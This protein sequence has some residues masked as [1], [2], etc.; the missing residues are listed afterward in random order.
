V[1]IDPP[2]RRNGKCIVCGGPR[3]P[4]RSRTYGG[5]VAELDPFCCTEHCKIWHGVVHPVGV[6]GKRL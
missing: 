2:I 5:T 3:N 6:K 4:S 1:R